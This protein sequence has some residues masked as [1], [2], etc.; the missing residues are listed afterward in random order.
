MTALFII[1]G[2]LVIFFVVTLLLPVFGSKA[3]PTAKYDKLLDTASQRGQIV[4]ATVVTLEA[5]KT[6]QLEVKNFDRQ[7]SAVYKNKHPLERAY[8]NIPD[9]RMSYRPV[10]KYS[11]G[12]REHKEGYHSCISDRELLLRDGQ[13]VR[14]CVDPSSPGF[15]V[16]LGDKASYKFL[17]QIV[18]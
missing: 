11:F 15:Y 7:H 9:S 17:K 6:G 14:I 13:T 12:G 3:M 16:I 1:V 5:V 2:A 10:L 18:K 4:T 8:L